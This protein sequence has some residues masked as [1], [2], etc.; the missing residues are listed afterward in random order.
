[1]KTIIIKRPAQNKE[2]EKFSFPRFH[3]DSVKK[4]EGIPSV[5]PS[6]VIEIKIPQEGKITENDTK[7]GLRPGHGRSICF[8]C[9]LHSAVYVQIGERQCKGIGNKRTAVFVC[10]DC[11][12]KYFRYSNHGKYED[13][14]D[15]SLSSS[16][17]SFTSSPDFSDCVFEGLASLEKEEIQKIP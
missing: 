16:F 1:M 17:Y 14:A 11:Y 5:E 12:L 10:S 6:S 3:S 13:Q 8:K 9:K 15:T 4:S 2:V 7:K